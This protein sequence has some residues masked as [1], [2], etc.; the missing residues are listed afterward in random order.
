MKNT[1]LKSAL[2]GRTSTLPAQGQQP[3]SLNAARLST[4]NTPLFTRALQSPMAAD[5]R[6]KL[7]TN[8]DGYPV[9]S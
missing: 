3:H 2:N 8:E 1:R 6:F 4:Q 9:A 7:T 5:T